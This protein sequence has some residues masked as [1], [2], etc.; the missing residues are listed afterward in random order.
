MK[1]VFKKNEKHAIS[2]FQSIDGQEKEFSYVDMVKYLI[3]SRKMDEPE[4]SSGFGQAEIKSINRM[5][6]FINKQ[7]SLA[8]EIDSVS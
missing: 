1:L 3:E 2:V 7:I 8:D 6:E 5:V 4:I